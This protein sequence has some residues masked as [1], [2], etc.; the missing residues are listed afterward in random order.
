MGTKAKSANYSGSTA[1]IVRIPY[2]VAIKS[3]VNYLYAISEI[4]IWST[5]EVGL[6]LLTAG[7]ATLQPLWK[8]WFGKTVTEASHPSGWHRTS[9]KESTKNNVYKLKNLSSGNKAYNIATVL[10]PSRRRSEVT[11]ADSFDTPLD[12]CNSS[13]Q[14]LAEHVTHVSKTSDYGTP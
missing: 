8:S 5:V 4:C 2:L 10:H 12:G 1:T 14:N 9:S 7:L 3:Q 6:S 13:Q 11:M